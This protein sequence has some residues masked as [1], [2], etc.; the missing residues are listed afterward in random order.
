MTDKDS[1]DQDKL[2]E[3]MQALNEYYMDDGE[4]GGKATFAAFASEHANKEFVGDEI[5]ISDEQKLEYT[6]VHNQYK[7]LFE[8]AL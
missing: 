6:E 5:K 2:N 7:E 1:V 8:A 4:C 3:I